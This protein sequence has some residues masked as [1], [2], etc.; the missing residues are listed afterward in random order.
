MR[1]QVILK[2]LLLL[3]Q[4]SFVWYFVNE[5]LS[6]TNNFRRVQIFFF[7]RWVRT[8]KLFLMY[9]YV[10]YPVHILIPQLERD[11]T[12]MVKE[13]KFK[14]SE[15]LRVTSQ[16]TLHWS[17]YFYSLGTG[18]KSRFVNHLFWPGYSWF[19]TL[20]VVK[21]RIVCFLFIIYYYI[22][23]LYGTVWKPRRRWEDNIKMDLQ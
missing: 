21:S 16:K 18:F 1:S 15:M 2:I 19:F 12:L 3:L 22:Y 6:K 14:S 7:W 4:H 20:S 10:F 9:L 8:M 17:A 5:Y 11:W 23:L 13:S